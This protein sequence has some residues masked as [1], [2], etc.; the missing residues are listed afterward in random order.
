[1]KLHSL[2][3]MDE[4]QGSLS[5]HSQYLARSIITDHHLLSYPSNIESQGK[6][7]PAVTV[8]EDDIFKDALPDFLTSSDTSEVSIREKDQSKG[9][10]VPGDVFYEALGSDDSDFVSVTFSTRDPSSPDYDGI[11]AQVIF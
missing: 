8:E 1:M 9:K 5:S 7:L 6:D 4:L 10:I 11:D 2:K 3:I